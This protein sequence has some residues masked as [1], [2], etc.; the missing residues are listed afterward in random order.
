VSR[1][2]WTVEEVRDLGATTDIPT[3]GEIL[4]GVGKKQAYRRVEAGEFPVP[5]FCAGRRKYVAVDAILGQLRSERPRRDVLKRGDTL[6]AV[7]D[8]DG[9]LMGVV[10][11]DDLNTFHVAFDADG[12]TMGMV[13]PDDLM[14]S[15]AHLLPPVDDVV[16]G[17]AEE[18]SE[19][20]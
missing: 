10:H 15:V 11:P 13:H 16:A 14:W 6:R 7:F 17:W 12:T 18:L 9:N 2:T 8:V 19:D 3:A 4:L 5:V 1:R 20:S